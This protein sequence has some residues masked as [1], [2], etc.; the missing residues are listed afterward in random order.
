MGTQQYQVFGGFVHD[1]AAASISKN[2]FQA[3]YQYLCSQGYDICSI[4]N[5][6]M[7]NIGLLMES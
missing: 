7:L 5:E 1:K 3:V 4:Q 2:Q 6:D